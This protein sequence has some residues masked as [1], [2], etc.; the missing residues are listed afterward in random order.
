MRAIFKYALTG[1][2]RQ[3]INLP[4]LAQPLS[5]QLQQG[6]PHLWALVDTDQPIQRYVVLAYWTGHEVQELPIGHE[7]LG[8]LQS[9][10][11]S[12]VFHFFGYFE[13]R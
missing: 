5:L 11:G 12:L 1:S 7:F 8:T 4:A 3:I 9:S 13:S 2:S 10:D 6:S